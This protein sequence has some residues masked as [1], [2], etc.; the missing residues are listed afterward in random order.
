MD[1]DF[2]GPTT[3]TV[4]VAASLSQSRHGPGTLLIPGHDE[5]RTHPGTH[6]SGRLDQPEY[7]TSTCG[8]GA[9]FNFC[10]TH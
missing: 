5:P 6:N 9:A 1:W 7:H 4:A 10:W 2:R 3:R 8:L